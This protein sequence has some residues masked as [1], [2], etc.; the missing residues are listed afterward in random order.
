[1]TAT[2]FGAQAASS[3]VGGASEGLGWEEK[4]ALGCVWRRGGGGG[5][6]GHRILRFLA[7][8]KSRKKT[9]EERQAQFRAV[10][11]PSHREGLKTQGRVGGTHHE[12]S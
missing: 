9:P 7:A 5:H 6:P 12:G 2:R 8:K 10:G 1:M 11:K 4:P 3:T